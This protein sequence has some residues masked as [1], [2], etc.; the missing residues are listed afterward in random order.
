MKSMPKDSKKENSSQSPTTDPKVYIILLNWN[1]WRDTL[2][3]LDSI[4][5]L[6]YSNAEVVVVD[7]GSTDDSVHKIREAHPDIILH[8]SKSNLGYAGGNNIGIRYALKQGAEYVWILNNDTVVDENALTSLIDKMRENPRIGICG[9]RLI[10]Y[11]QRDTLQALAG[12]SYNKW[13]GTVNHVGEN[14]PALASYDE[15]QIQEEM[16]YVVGAS[17]L[18]SKGFIDEVGLL[19]EDYFLYYEEMDWAARGQNFDLGFASDSIVYHKEGASTKGSS[20]KKST[21]S[22]LSDYYQIKNRFK[23]SLKYFPYYLPFIYLATMVTIFNRIRRRQWN[24]I[25]MILKLFFTFNH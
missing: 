23:F 9:S 4:R 2:E 19:N 15:D 25:P 18:V 20:Q 10:Y 13:T 21:K 6:R 3:C 7:N 17:M 22:R 24:R 8:E 1:G 16:D 5:K 14:K 11:H 12:G